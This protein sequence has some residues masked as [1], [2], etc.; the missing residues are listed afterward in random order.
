[1][2][3]LHHMDAILTEAFHLLMDHGEDVFALLP[4]N[5]DLAVGHDLIHTEPFEM[6][7]QVVLGVLGLVQVALLPARLETPETKP[8]HAHHAPHVHVRGDIRKS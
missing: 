4:P 3:K 1:M 7:R 8:S 6:L 5:T 2:Q